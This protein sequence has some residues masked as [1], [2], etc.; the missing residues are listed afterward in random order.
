[1]ADR[2]E[3]LLD[4]AEAILEGKRNGFGLPI[5]RHL[6]LR[7]YGP[8]LLSLAGRLTDTGTRSDLG[9]ISQAYSPVGMMY[10]A[11]RLGESNAPQ[12]MAM[13]LFNV[14][15]LRGYRHWMHRAARAGDANAANEL[16][17]FETRKP[18]NLAGKL[19]RLRPY[20]RDGS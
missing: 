20:R 15:D 4:R 16:M 18:H 19:H 11:Y 10:R 3:K 8:A 13:S 14:G 2:F 17:L 12:N 9:R 7:R 1:M 6:A 5:L